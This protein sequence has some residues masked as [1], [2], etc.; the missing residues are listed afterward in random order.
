MTTNLDLCTDCRGALPAAARFCPHCGAR[1]VAA[2]AP[3]PAGER[4]QVTIVFADLVGYTRL[5]STLDPEETHRLLTHFF[6]RADA[7]V[8]RWGGTIDK[9]IGD[10][11]MA[12]FG[13]PV[14]YG[15]D[16]ERALRAAVDIHGAMAALSAEFGRQLVTHVGIASGEVVAATTGS[17]AHRNY[18]VTGDAVNLAARLTDLA[19]GGETVVSHDVQRTLSALAEF[20][21]LG[22]VPIHGL[23]DGAPAF[24]VAAL[25]ATDAVKQ[26]LLGRERERQR[27]AGLLQHAASA[28]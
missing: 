10:A 18:T 27:F 24:R 7:V 9:H 6:E 12:V 20:D 21:P 26:P 1:V 4:R 11:V 19:R 22:T 13:A 16:V 15:N 28:Q 8:T 14:A 23:A 17:A 3:A 25:R 2:A 5:S